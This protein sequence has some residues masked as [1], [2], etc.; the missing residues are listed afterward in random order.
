M[1]ANYTVTRGGRGFIGDA[2]AQLLN[3][4]AADGQ[5]PQLV[6]VVPRMLAYFATSP[7]RYE[8]VEADVLIEALEKREDS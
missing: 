4:M 3:K 1:I 8:V 2:V 5:R 6:A 7:E